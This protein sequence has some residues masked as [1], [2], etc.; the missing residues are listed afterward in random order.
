MDPDE[1]LKHFNWSQECQEWIDKVV[2]FLS[3]Q[4]GPADL[5]YS[6]GRVDG[7]SEL[8]GK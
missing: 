7:Q 3:F 6:N 1:R 5:N 2:M 4:K 8:V